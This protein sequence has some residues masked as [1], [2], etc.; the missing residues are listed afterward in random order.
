MLPSG[1]HIYYCAHLDL[2]RCTQTKVQSPYECINESFWNDLVGTQYSK[3]F[4]SIKIFGGFVKMSF[5]VEKNYD[6]IWF[7]ILCYKESTLFEIP[8]INNNDTSSTTRKPSFS[9]F[10][11]TAWQVFCVNRNGVW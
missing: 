7:S 11:N 8:F 10:V 2:I 6:L 3:E 4:Q 1:C 5:C 9:Q